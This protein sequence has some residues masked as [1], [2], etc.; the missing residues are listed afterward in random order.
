[1]AAPKCKKARNEIV[2]TWQEIINKSL[3]P[4]FGLIMHVV[5]IIIKIFDLKKG[6]RDRMVS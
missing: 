1:M 3:I 4:T 6:N 5:I 2:K